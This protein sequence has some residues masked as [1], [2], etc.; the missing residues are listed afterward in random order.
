[1]PLRPKVHGYAAGWHFRL[2]PGPRC[3]LTRS[4]ILAGF[5]GG[6]GYSSDGD[7]SAVSWLIHRTGVTRG[8][9][10]GHSAWTKR[11]ATHPRVLAALAA[12]QVSESVG[13]LICVWTDK[14][15]DK[16]RD[17]AD[18]QL[19]AAAAGGLG[20]EELAGLFAEMYERA[21]SERPDEDPDRDFADRGGK[22]AATFGGAG[23]LY[24]DLTREC[25]EVVGRVLDAL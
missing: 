9:A 19:L 22:L 8:A 2:I 7:Y 23:L 24:G 1:M 6:K 25:A 17:Q 5:T 15:P 12:G 4:S 20:L 18:E 21:R 11:T 10:V 16:A 14:L 3:I 13:R